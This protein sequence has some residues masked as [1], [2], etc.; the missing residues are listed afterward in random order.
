MEA[1]YQPV[2][3]M[4]GFLLT[5]GVAVGIFRLGLM[6]GVSNSVVSATEKLDT[7]VDG[8]IATNTQGHQAIREDI[9]K[10]GE[11]LARVETRIANLPCN[12]SCILDPGE[13]T[14]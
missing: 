9:G 3:L 14:S 12:G 13:D 10:T 1:Y 6:I 11:R 7:K 5:G 8:F 4:L 2:Q